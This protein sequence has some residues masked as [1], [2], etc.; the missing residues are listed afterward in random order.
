MEFTIDSD[1]FMFV[2]DPLAHY[3]EQTLLFLGSG[4]D[5][6]GGARPIF[7]ADLNNTDKW[8]I[9]T[10]DTILSA[11]LTIFADSIEGSAGSNDSGE[12]IDDPLISVTIP[13]Q[14]PKAMTVDL[15][16]FNELHD[17]DATHLRSAGPVS[18]ASYPVGVY[19]HRP[20]ALH[21]PAIHTSSWNEHAGGQPWSTYGA[22]STLNDIY[23]GAYTEFE[24]RS[25]PNLPD[26]PSD[27]AMYEIDV[28]EHAKYAV[29]DRDLEFCVQM[30]RGSD[31]TG[32]NN[33][34]LT[35][36]YSVDHPTVNLRPKLTITY[37]DQS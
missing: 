3:H 26:I 1:T 30:Y 36:I 27:D 11:T 5:F 15:N 28:T 13:A 18:Y 8:G 31:D 19:P 14:T 20:P 35:K 21:H 7:K 24:L 25:S 34:N 32:N 29:S 22:G 16:T 17:A 4:G 2:H 6:T 9:N 37:L 12:E 33:E 23:S 10:N